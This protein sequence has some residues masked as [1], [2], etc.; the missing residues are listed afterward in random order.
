MSIASWV[1]LRGG[2]YRHGEGTPG[3]PPPL[4]RPP[5]SL[6]DALDKETTATTAGTGTT[7][8]VVTETREVKVRTY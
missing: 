5:R 4:T 1:T 2:H 8:R 6:R 7:Q 3:V